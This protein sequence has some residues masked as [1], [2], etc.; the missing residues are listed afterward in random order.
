M[1]LARH[2]DVTTLLLEWRNGYQEA[3][4]V[5]MPLV[6]EQVHKLAAR[7]LRLEHSAHTLQTTAMVHEVYLKLIDQRRVQFE[8]REHFFAAAAQ[9]I[10][11]ILVAH[12]RKRRS[13]KRGGCKTM[14]TLDEATALP[15]QKHVDLVALDDLLASLSKIDPQQ[16]RIVELRFFGGLTILE[17]ADVLGISTATVSR[18]WD[19]ARAWLRRELSRNKV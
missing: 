12:A 2:K 6:Y 18:D 19:L 15:G 3:L 1:G 5:L 4:N 13:L 11:H 10:R 16:G 17:T 7:Q 8:D 14:L 9:M